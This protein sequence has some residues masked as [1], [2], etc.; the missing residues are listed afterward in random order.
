MV[1]FPITSPR[2]LSADFL[3][4]HPPQ[5]TSLNPA[6]PPATQLLTPRPDHFTGSAATFPFDT[7]NPSS[8]VLF[9]TG[10]TT[11]FFATGR[12]FTAPSIPS[13]HSIATALPPAIHP[14]QLRQATQK[15]SVTASST[16]RKCFHQSSTKPSHSRP[17]PHYRRIFPTPLAPRRRPRFQRPQ[18]FTAPTPEFAPIDGTRS[19]VHASAS[20]LLIE[21]IV[22]PVRSLF[23]A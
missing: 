17:H 16:R 13:Q 11:F 7:R 18:S 3:G 5:S 14:E 8:D 21:S 6:L 1:P 22:D 9:T 15:T 4:I 23:R 10:R 12:R 19:I 20:A 2:P